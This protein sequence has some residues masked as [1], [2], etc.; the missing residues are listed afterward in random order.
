MII[1]NDVNSFFFLYKN[2][3]KIL[4]YFSVELSL[5]TSTNSCLMFGV[6]IYYHSDV[7]IICSFLI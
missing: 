5:K 2:Q 4:R 6:A 7:F 1:L 3:Q